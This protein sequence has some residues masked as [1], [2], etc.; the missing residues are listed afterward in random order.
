M[1]SLAFKRDPAT[2][3]VLSRRSIAGSLIA[4]FVRLI[5]DESRTANTVPHHAASANKTGR[6]ATSRAV[7]AQNNE[8]PSHLLAQARTHDCRVT[9]DETNSRRTI[10][11]VL[12]A[13]VAVRM[14][15]H[16]ALTSSSYSINF[17]S[18]L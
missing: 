8:T 16:P 2:R 18:R 7:N 3:R 13:R 14:S 10:T 12:V 6:P 4:P 5:Y 17:F 1:L 11:R 15:Y 9:H